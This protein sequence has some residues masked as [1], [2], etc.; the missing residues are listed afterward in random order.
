MVSLIAGGIFILQRQRKLLVA[1]V[2]HMEEV[3][4]SMVNVT[5]TIMEEEPYV[6]EYV[7]DYSDDDYSKSMFFNK[8]RDYLERSMVSPV[9]LIDTSLF[10]FS[11]SDLNDMLLIL[12][13]ERDGLYTYGSEFANS[14]LE[15]FR[16]VVK[17]IDSFTEIFTDNKT[18]D[19]VFAFIAPSQ[20]T[21]T[22]ALTMSKAQ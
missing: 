15:S 3:D 16:V 22:I 13:K 2:N 21:L 8:I 7:I 4:S 6:Y 1:Q 10:E 11:L 19:I 5:L 17:G 20:Q 12:D 14:H 18:L 9:F